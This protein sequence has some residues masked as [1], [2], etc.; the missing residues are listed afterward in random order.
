M[1]NAFGAPVV[2][3]GKKTGVSIRPDFVVIVPGYKSTTN[4]TEETLKDIE[5]RVS[6][7]DR[8]IKM[9]SVGDTFTTRTH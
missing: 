6:E 9:F 2:H 1:L 4:P 8:Y 7:T 3:T 5:V